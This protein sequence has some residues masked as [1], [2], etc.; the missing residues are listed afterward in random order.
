MEYSQ[1]EHNPE[2]WE[3]FSKVLEKHFYKLNRKIIVDRYEWKIPFSGGYLRIGVKM[4]K[5][6]LTGKKDRQWFYWKWDKRR[7]T[8][9]WPKASSWMFVPVRGQVKNRHPELENIGEKGLEHHLA[10]ISKDPKKPAYLVF[11]KRRAGKGVSF[12]EFLKS[13]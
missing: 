7:N 8:H 10:M 11:E 1:E 6:K 9:L 13:I 3:I 2:T 12:S 4:V 5:N